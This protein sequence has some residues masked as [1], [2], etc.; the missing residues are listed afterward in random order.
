VNQ[1]RSFSLVALLLCGLVLGCSS[2]ETAD[3]AQ[4]PEGMVLVKAGKFALGSDD[5]GLLNTPRREAEIA[6]PFFLDAKEVTN[7]EYAAFVAEKGVKAPGYWPEG[8]V[9]EGREE[10]PVYGVSF[11]DA[12][13]FAK[14][15]EKR[16]PTEEEWERAARG[17][18]GLEYP[19]GNEFDKTKCNAYTGQKQDTTPVGTYGSGKSACGAFDLAG[20]VWEWTTSDAPEAGKKIIKGADGFGVTDPKT[21]RRGACDPSK[22]YPNDEVKD[23]YVGFRCAKSGPAPA[24]AAAE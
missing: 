1:K 21:A 4:P 24:A 19:W 22:G 5:E 3:P 2:T 13:A 9:P 6:A 18:N 7:K 16:L 11:L 12:E 10:H 8:K 15:K 14:W 23:L 17:T 20:N